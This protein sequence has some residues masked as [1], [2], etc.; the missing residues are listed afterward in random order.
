MA[1]LTENI[2]KVCKSQLEMKSTCQYMSVTTTV[3]KQVHVIKTKT[4]KYLFP[5]EHSNIIVI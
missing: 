2:Q 1:N 5:D 3:Y 4:A